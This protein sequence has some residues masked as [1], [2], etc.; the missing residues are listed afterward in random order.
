MGKVFLP[1]KPELPLRPSNNAAIIIVPLLINGSSQLIGLLIGLDI[2]SAPMP[3]I[4]LYIPSFIV[5]TLVGG[6]QEELGW[7]GYLQGELMP[8]Y[9]LVKTSSFIGLIWGLWH[10]PLWFMI[11][12]EHYFTPYIGFVL[13]TISLSF[14]FSYIYVKTDANKPIMVLFHGST[15]AAMSVLY[16]LY[17]NNPAS[18]QSLYWVYV[19]VNILAALIV[20]FL[21]RK[22]KVSS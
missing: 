19:G 9:G 14:V 12:D 15:N 6:G 16:L 3:D 1:G 21:T 17:A 10:A 5:V 4:W 2:P 7:R 13:M 11:H 20:V 22:T 18:D 8:K